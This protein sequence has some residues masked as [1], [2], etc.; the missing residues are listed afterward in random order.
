MGARF[1]RRLRVL[2]AEL[3]R[4]QAVL[5]FKQVAH[6][7]AAGKALLLSD[8]LYR[9][10]RRRQL[11]RGFAQA[12]PGD[13]LHKADAHLFAEQ[14]REPGL[15]NKLRGGYLLQRQAPLIVGVDSRHHSVNSLAPA[16]GS[17]RRLGGEGTAEA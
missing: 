14:T 15:R 16:F 11:L 4:R 3:A 13:V 8:L 12:Q 1:A 7:P 17:A 5:A 6:H 10:T 9:L 2:L